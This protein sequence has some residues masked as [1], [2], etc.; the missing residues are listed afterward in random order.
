M[1]KDISSSE[2]QGQ[3]VGA[4]GNKSGKEMKCRMFTSRRTCKHATL[5]FFARFISSRP[6]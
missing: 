3:L 2:T 6:D 4:G 1:S 5:H